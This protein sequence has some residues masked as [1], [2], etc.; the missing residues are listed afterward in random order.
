MTSRSPQR[1]LES[2]PKRERT[3]LAVLRAYHYA[4]RTVAYRFD[5]IPLD[6]KIETT[7]ATG[8]SATNLDALDSM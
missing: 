7:V 5:S 1:G 3:G 8:F 6:W 2:E 4:L